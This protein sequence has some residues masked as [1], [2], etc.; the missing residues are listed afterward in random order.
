MRSISCQVIIKST[1]TLPGWLC[2][3]S[4][5][6]FNLLI[7][8]FHM[9]KVIGQKTAL[10]I[11]H[12]EKLLL[13]TIGNWGTIAWYFVYVV[14]TFLL[15]HVIKASLIPRCMKKQH[16]HS[17]FYWCMFVKNVTQTVVLFCKG[18]EAIIKGLKRKF[19]STPYRSRKKGVSNFCSYCVYGMPITKQVICT[20]KKITVFV[21]GNLS[22]PENCTFS[23]HI[24]NSLICIKFCFRNCIL[25]K[26]T[27][28]KVFFIFIS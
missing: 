25:L 3:F 11:N 24:Y 1:A 5:Y 9:H 2:K 13:I 8:K 28:Y 20:F 4:Y 18:I 6:D 14:S 7:K 21:K 12:S 16:D 15:F 27:D 22:L 17:H 10:L 19:A 23:P 26:L